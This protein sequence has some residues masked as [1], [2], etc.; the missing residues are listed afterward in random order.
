L[1]LI[2]YI[3]A[4][5]LGLAVFGRTG[6]WGT[7]L[8][9]VWTIGMTVYFVEFVAMMLVNYGTFLTARRAAIARNKARMND[10][11]TEVLST[12]KSEGA[13]GE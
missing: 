6:N 4:G 9:L 10:L 1:V 13:S 7:D 8:S 12:S 5:I 11:L 2:K 3:L